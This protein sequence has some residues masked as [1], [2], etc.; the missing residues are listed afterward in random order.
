MTHRKLSHLS[1]MKSGLIGRRQ[2]LQSAAGAAA[3]SMSGGFGLRQ[4]VA[5]ASG[6]TLI[7]AMY[8]DP[9]GLDPQLNLQTESFQAMLAC[10]EQ[11]YDYD[12]GTDSYTLTA[13]AEASQW[14]TSYAQ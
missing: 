9:Q 14:R 5:Q 12:P 1:G 7:A 4:A 2:F 8:Q 13:L 10:Y 6:G 11:L 3:F